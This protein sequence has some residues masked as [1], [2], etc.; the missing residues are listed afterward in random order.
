MIIIKCIPSKNII[1]CFKLF[2]FLKYNFFN[3]KSCDINKNE[4]IPIKIGTQNNFT[5]NKSTCKFENTV[6]IE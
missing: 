4:K 2:S 6:K 5:K 3:I 1:Y